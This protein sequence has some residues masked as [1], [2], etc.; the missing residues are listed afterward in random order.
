M[1][2][3]NENTYWIPETNGKTSNSFTQIKKSWRRIKQ[4]KYQKKLWIIKLLK[5][6]SFQ[7][8]IHCTV[9]ISFKTE[10]KTRYTYADILK[11]HDN[12]MRESLMV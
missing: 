6:Q 5:E 8:K 9:K 3:M 7:T 1:I 2:K 10:D 4:K 12:K 11:G